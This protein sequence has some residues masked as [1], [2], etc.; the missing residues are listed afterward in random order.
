[1]ILLLWALSAAGGAAYVLPRHVRP[2]HS[3]AASSIG[4]A[5]GTSEWPE[6]QVGD[7]VAFAGEWPGDSLVGQIEVLR[8]SS[9]PRTRW[10]ADVV[11]LQDQAQQLWRVPSYTRAK[12]KRNAVD[13]SELVPLAAEYV[14]DSDAWRIARESGEAPTK[15]LSGSAVGLVKRA[16]GYAELADDF[17]PLTAPIDV[18]KARR[19]LRNY[20]SLKDR[21][22]RDSGIAAAVGTV[23]AFAVGGVDD[24]GAFAVGA[25]A[26]VA[27]VALLSRAA[28][29]A[30]QSKDAISSARF[31]PLVLAFAVLGAYHCV[32]DAVRPQMLSLIPKD[33]FLAA[34]AGVLSYRIPLVYREV[35]EGVTTDEVLQILPGSVGAGARLRQE[36]DK[37][38][39]YM[40]DEEIVYTAAQTVLVVSGPAGAGKTTLV[41]RLL[42]EDPGRFAAPA[43]F[44]PKTLGIDPLEVGAVDSEYAVVHEADTDILNKRPAQAL[45]RSELIDRADG[46][47]AVVDADV[48]T[49]RQLAQLDGARLVGVWVSHDN[50]DALED[51]LTMLESEKALVV[52]G[53]GPGKVTA[54]LVNERVRLRL[55]TVIDDL[56]FGIRTPMF[57][58]TIINSA[59][60]DDAYAKIKRASK[61]V[62][63]E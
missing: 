60:V 15:E 11:P 28:D 8:R 26:A 3:L 63:D 16:D 30:G 20:N 14:Q 46:R 61:F 54:I 58:F 36:K 59:S 27:Y 22:L 52:D 39:A 38:A 9:V 12:Q 55:S 23:G 50:L 42:A 4:G 29:K 21:L 31:A 35:V 10:V 57:D 5:A 13:V 18:D 45:L 40:P 44:A 6:P 49:A 51:R 1:M 37:P 53:L 34:L 62:F 33:E 19:A 24:A 25:G 41:N 7:I 56:D 48:D 32:A 2:A 47:T 43:W 17:K